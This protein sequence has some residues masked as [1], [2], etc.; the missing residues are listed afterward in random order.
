MLPHTLTEGGIPFVRS[1]N[2][3]G[4]GILL[5]GILFPFVSVKK[6]KVLFP[7]VSVRANFESSIRIPFPLMALS[8]CVNP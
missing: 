3:N 2:R 8:F 4:N 6:T 5:N 7:F 1:A